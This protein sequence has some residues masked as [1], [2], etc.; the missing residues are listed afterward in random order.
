M[1]F[2]SEAQR[3]FM[4]ARHPKIAA[5]WEEHTEKKRLPKKVGIGDAIKRIKNRG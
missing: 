3:R 2:K 4:Y 5:R 1:P